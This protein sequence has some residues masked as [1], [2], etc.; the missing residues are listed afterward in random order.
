LRCRLLEEDVGPGIDEEGKTGAIG[1]LARTSDPRFLV[2]HV[3][4]RSVVREAVFE[5]AP[6]GARFDCAQYAMRNLINR[7]AIAAFQIDRYRQIGGGSDAREVVDGEI[8]RKLLAVRE[9]VGCC[10]RPASRCDGASPRCADRL[11]A[12]GIPDVEQHERF[13]AHMQCPK[14]LGLEVLRRHH[15][16]LQCLPFHISP[17]PA[18]RWLL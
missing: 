7:L 3:T 13:S 16:V 6:D 12:A 15:H 9:P 1:G 2:A 14:S 8:E 4:Q 11:C 18:R 10:D 5:V 17:L